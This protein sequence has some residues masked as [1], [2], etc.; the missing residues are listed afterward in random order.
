MLGIGQHECRATGASPHQARGSGSLKE[1]IGFGENRM[2]IRITSIPRTIEGS[3]PAGMPRLARRPGRPR[4]LIMVK[5]GR[6]R[7]A[8]GES[9]EEMMAPLSGL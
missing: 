4:A 5:Q 7:P 9:A 6:P 8:G 2:E 3:P 1:Y